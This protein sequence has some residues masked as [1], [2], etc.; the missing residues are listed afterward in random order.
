MTNIK[1]ALAEKLTKK[2]INQ[3][4]NII[5]NFNK[6]FKKELQIRIVNELA[7]KYRNYTILLGCTELALMLKKFDLD[8]INTIDVLVDVTIRNLYLKNEKINDFRK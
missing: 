7:K 4:S 2:E 5:F 3:L 8:I 1:E 6:G